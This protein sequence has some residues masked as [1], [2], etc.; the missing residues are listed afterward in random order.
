MHSYEDPFFHPVDYAPT[1]KELIDRASTA[2]RRLTVPHALVLEML[3]S[4]LQAARYR[5]PEVMFIIQHLVLRTARAFSEM[6]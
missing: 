2:A 6:R 3:F 4:R 5:K 1:D